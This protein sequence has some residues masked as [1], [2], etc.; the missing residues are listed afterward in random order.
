M[1]IFR[2][3]RLAA[4]LLMVG[5]MGLPHAAHGADTMD[6]LF[7]T[8]KAD[9]TKFAG[10]I[11]RVTQERAGVLDFQTTLKPHEKR[12]SDAIKLSADWDR[13]VKWSKDN[14]CDL[15]KGAENFILATYEDRN[16]ILKTN[17]DKAHEAKKGSFT[18]NY[19]FFGKKYAQTVN[20]DFTKSEAMMKA[21]AGRVEKQVPKRPD[22]SKPRKAHAAQLP[23]LAWGQK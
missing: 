20:W 17:I 22:L 10:E 11:S 2:T 12:L 9:Y 21:Y 16:A 13:W 14:A 4:G 3:F 23:K 5:A 15:A 1:T 6:G 7:A 8:A 19:T 18:F